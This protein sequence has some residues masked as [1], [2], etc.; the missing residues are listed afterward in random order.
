[1]MMG[2]ESF[3]SLTLTLGRLGKLQ[4]GVGDAC[5]C[6]SQHHF[7]SSEAFGPGPGQWLKCVGRCH[8]GCGG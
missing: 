1:M 5:N 2:Q 8:S 3:L 4:C 6:C 7:G